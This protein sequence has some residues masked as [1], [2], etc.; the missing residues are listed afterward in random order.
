MS[1]IIYKIAD[2]QAWRDA[3][4]AGVYRGSPDDLRDGFIHFAT[5]DQ[6]PGTLAKHFAGHDG[7]M[8]VA[9]DAD[10]LGD[11]L[12]WEPSRGGQ[13]FPHLYD[14]LPADAALWATPLPLKDDGT[15]DMPGGL[16]GE[17]GETS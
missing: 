6:L 1:T 11:K 3:Q 13:L 9:I 10:R 15:H 4:E 12:V 5:A 8:L 7:L 14:A 17:A 16:G 2:A